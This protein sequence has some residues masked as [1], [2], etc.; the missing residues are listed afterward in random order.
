MS[1]GGAEFGPLSVSRFPT[2]SVFVADFRASPAHAPGAAASGTPASA[3]PAPA[4]LRSCRRSKHRVV[5]S[6]LTWSSFVRRVL[7]AATVPPRRVVVKI[8]ANLVDRPRRVRRT[9][10][11]PVACL[12]AGNFFDQNFSSILN[13]VALG[14]LIFVLAIGLSLI[15]GLLDVLNLAH[16]SLYLLGT[17]VG[18]ELVENEGLPFVAA[19]GISIV[20]GV[21]LGLVLAAALLPI[22][23]RGHLDQVLLTLGLFFIVADLITI[24]W[25]REF[26]TITPPHFLLQ[27]KVIFGHYYPSYRLAVIVV[28]VV[29]ALGAY[30]VFERTQLGAI[31]RA[32]VEDR[33]MVAA[34]GH[35]V[36]LITLSVLL[37]GSAL[38][39]FAGVIG[40]PIEQV[41][42]GVGDDVLLLALIVVVVGGLGSIS[43]AF[44]ASLIIG[45]AQSL[46]VALGQQHGLPQAAPFALFAAMALI[47]IARPQGLFGK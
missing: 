22:R 26:H 17:Y 16:G 1:I 27:S 24:L 10:F 33:A 32:A 35:N 34:L 8:V 7:A 14:M 30:L 43:G 13:G 31:L 12:L 36:K 15:F 37:A 25:G 21:A 2:R 4:R 41:T 44:V 45:Q 38:A 28:G 20:F 23:A 29:I 9:M 40:G 46:G 5:L 18:Y 39:T 42:P 6:S 47:L 19:A 11:S 3:A